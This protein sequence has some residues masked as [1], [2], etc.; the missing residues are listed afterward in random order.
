MVEVESLLKRKGELADAKP[1]KKEKLPWGSSVG[2]NK[3]GERS[4][5]VLTD[6]RGVWNAVVGPEEEQVHTESK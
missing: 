5:F 3:S 4:T 1:I 2:G 6:Q